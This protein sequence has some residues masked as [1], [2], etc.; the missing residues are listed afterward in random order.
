MAFYSV[1]I[2]TPCYV[3]YI[4]IVVWRSKLWD[5]PNCQ[6]MINSKLFEISHIKSNVIAVQCT[7]LAGWIS[8]TKKNMSLKGIKVLQIHSVHLSIIFL[9]SCNF[10]KLSLISIQKMSKLNDDCSDVNNKVNLQYPLG[11]NTS[12]SLGQCVR[13]HRH[14][15]T[16]LRQLRMS[17]NAPILELFNDVWKILM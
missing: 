10:Y 1:M 12:A 9:S 17:T 7:N 16:A 8:V 4:V 6:D 11:R 5:K 15:N 14:G 13:P 2:L 3:S